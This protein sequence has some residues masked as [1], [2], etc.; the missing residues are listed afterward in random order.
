MGGLCRFVSWTYQNN[1]I[2][3]TLIYSRKC[4]VFCEMFCFSVC[5]NADVFIHQND[6]II[7][8][9]ILLGCSDHDLWAMLY[10]VSKFWAF[11]FPDHSMV[12]T[13]K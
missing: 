3:F 5:Q 7:D 8:H 9:L 10:V 4:D 1:E 11:K 13:L 2:A 6:N 12:S